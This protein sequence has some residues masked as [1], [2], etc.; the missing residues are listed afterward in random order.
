MKLW[1]AE[2]RDEIVGG[3]LCFFSS[4]VV[5][6]WAIHTKEKFFPLR[7]ASLLYYTLIKYS[8]ENDYRWIDL[9]RSGNNP[10]VVKFKE[11]FGAYPYK[12]YR[13]EHYSPHTRYLRNVASRLRKVVRSIW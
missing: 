2:Y 10:G 3:M 8:C 11:R 5:A 1:V 6:P 13:Y 7:P 9:G 4:K 12:S